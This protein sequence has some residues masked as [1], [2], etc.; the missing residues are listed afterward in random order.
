MEAAAMI[1]ELL[2]VIGCQC[3]NTVVP[4]I[5]VAQGFNQAPHLGVY[6][7]NSRVIESN[8]LVAPAAKTPWSEVRPVPIRIQIARLIRP[9]WRFPQSSKRLLLRVIRRMRIHQMQP[10]E[11]WRVTDRVDP[12]QCFIDY[13]VGSRKTA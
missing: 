6:P 9:D 11:K 10:K 8:D 12:V 3:K 13:R 5:L 2:P 7:S 1:E 4:A